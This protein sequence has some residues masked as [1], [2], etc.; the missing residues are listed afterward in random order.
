MTNRANHVRSRRAEDNQRRGEERVVPL[1]L[2][3]QSWLAAALLFSPWLL[4]IFLSQ[5]LFLQHPT[6]AL[7]TA[8]PCRDGDFFT[9]I[10]GRFQVKRVRG[11]RFLLCISMTQKICRKQR[12]LSDKI[13]VQVGT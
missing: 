2:R 13:M 10:S 1:G 6:A 5:P 4:T 9:G 11:N 3:H 12:L 7:A 8:A